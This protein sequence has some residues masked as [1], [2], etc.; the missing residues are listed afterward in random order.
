MNIRPFDGYCFLSL[1]LESLKTRSRRGKWKSMPR[2]F[3]LFVRFSCFKMYKKP[4]TIFLI[5]ILNCQVELM[6]YFSFLFIISHNNNLILYFRICSQDHIFYMYNPIRYEKKL[7]NTHERI[8]VV[9]LSTLRI[10]M[11][12]KGRHYDNEMF[13]VLTLFIPLSSP[14]GPLVIKVTQ[15]VN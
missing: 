5:Q 4:F 10:K 8:F 11:Y 15:Y 1:C 12:K 6:I 14:L 7:K 3:N 9:N 13:L 2:I